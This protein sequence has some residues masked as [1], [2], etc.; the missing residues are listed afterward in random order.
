MYGNPEKAIVG[1]KQNQQFLQAR[2]AL[3]PYL[4]RLLIHLCKRQ[5]IAE[6]GTAGIA[7]GSETT[8]ELCASAM[9]VGSLILVSKLMSSD[10]T[11][12]AHH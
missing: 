4:I 10:S 7:S 2:P 5:F 3:N 12:L 8:S 1:F 6:S 11:F 9:W